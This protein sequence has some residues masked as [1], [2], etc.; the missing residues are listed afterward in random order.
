MIQLKICGRAGNQFFQYAFVNNYLINNSLNEK[1]YISFED[2]KKHKSDN[3]SFLNELK[4]FKIFNIEEISKIKFERK[5]RILDFIY[6]VFIKFIRSKAKIKKERLNQQYYDI[7]IKR[8]QKILNINGLYYYIPGMKEFY[9]SKTENIIFYGSYEDARYY[10]KN[11]DNILEAFTPIKDK[12]DKNI[13][14]YK[15]IEEN[16]SVCV[17]IR[18]GDFL[19]DKYINNYYICNK[20]YFMRAIEKMNK[21]IKAPQY[22]VFSDDIEWCK[23]NIEFPSNTVFESGNDPIWEKIRL[24]YSCKHFIISNS[25]FSWWAQYLSRN[26]EKKVIAPKVWN[27]FEFA[28]LI[29]NDKWFLI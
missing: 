23:K 24:M 27:N 17:T 3:Y 14:L 25:T 26:K 21:L 20:D 18:R 12:I 4:N 8:L 2:L 13:S 10:L 11:R 5:Q 19:N 7:I 28:D 9:K 22:V 1:I 16:N 6:K 29:Y 15:I